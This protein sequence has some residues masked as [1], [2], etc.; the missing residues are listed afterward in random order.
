[1]DL[2]RD[3]KEFFLL[4]N[5]KKVKYLL[6]GGYAVSYHGFIRATGDIDIWVEQTHENAER[7]IQTL[8]AF[9]FRQ[10]KIDQEILLKENQIIRMGVPPLKIE[11]LT[12]LSGVSFANCYKKRINAKINDI[13]ISIINLADLKKNKKASSRLK[14]LNDLANLPK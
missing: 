5:E 1:M 13:P 6:V 3:F 10:T 11:L 4:L 9:G 14:D 7:V 2:P 8:H 12:T